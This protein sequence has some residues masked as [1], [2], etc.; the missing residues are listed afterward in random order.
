[1]NRIA[2]D[3]LASYRANYFDAVAQGT[4]RPY[5]M[6]WTLIPSFAITTVYLAIPHVRRPWLYHARW[7]VVV[8]VLA[9]NLEQTLNVSSPNVAAA[10]GAGMSATWGSMLCL[11]LL[12]WTRPQFEAARVIR[13]KK[14]EVNGNGH[15]TSSSTS[16]RVM[17][18]A[19][20]KANGDNGDAKLHHSGGDDD[21]V[22]VWQRFPEH[23]SFW[24]RL[25]WAWDLVSCFRGA[26]QFS[27]L[28]IL[29]AF[30]LT[31][32]RLE[33]VYVYHPATQRLTYRSQGPLTRGS[34]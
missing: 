6:P 13:V 30:I 5:V 28:L 20:G 23:E 27:P 33:L 21:Y 22:S 14:R 26:G 7:L 24:N 9:L 18:R 3:T 4:R 29:I 19:N 2:A 12:V 31:A 17:R 8:V 10:Y 32:S 15:A 25:G 11:N 34:I 1:M 16:G